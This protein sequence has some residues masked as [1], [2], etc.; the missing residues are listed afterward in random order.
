M[1][2]VPYS[3]PV[4]KIL[5]PAR[6]LTRLLFPA[7]FSPAEEKATTMRNFRKRDA[8]QLRITYVCCTI[9]DSLRMLHNH[10]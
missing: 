4:G 2:L 7:P 10:G 5:Q 3:M 1:V 9:R 6:R 8:T